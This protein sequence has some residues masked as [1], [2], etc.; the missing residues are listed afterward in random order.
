MRAFDP[1]ISW[2]LHTGICAHTG[3]TTEDT[4]DEF[5]AKVEAARAAA[6]VVHENAGGL[7]TSLFQRHQLTR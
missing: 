7:Y 6:T 2:L 4:D 3:D 1:P 5:V